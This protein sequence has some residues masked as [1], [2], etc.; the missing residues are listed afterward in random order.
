MNTPSL[1]IDIAKATFVAAL[2]LDAQRHIKSTFPN[3]GGGF[4]QLRR[5]LKSHGCGGALRVGLESTSTYADK[6]AHWLH[7]QGH[8][9]FLLNPQHASYYARSQGQRNKTDPADAVTLANL[10]AERAGLTPWAPPPPEQ[11]HLRAFTRARQQLVDHRQQLRNQLETAHPAVQPHLKAILA[12]IT[13]QIKALEKDL[14][15]H[16]RKHCTLHAQVQRLT[17][18]D[19]VGLITAAITVAELPPITAASDPRALAAWVGLTPCRHQSG[20][21][22]RPSHLSN[23]GNVYLRRALFMP[24]LVAKRHNPIL[25]AFAQK[26]AAKGKRPGSILGA[27]AHKLLRILVAL[28]RDQTDFNP[29]WSPQTF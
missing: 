13:E 26:L 14:R 9:V 27:I 3:H 8:S 6:L 15:N 23:K 29:N 22:E 10:I 16:L 19:G 5:W 1:G 17:T 12:S 2:R 25:H 18:V 4:P 21:I 24:A 7:A 20:N 28:L 11:L